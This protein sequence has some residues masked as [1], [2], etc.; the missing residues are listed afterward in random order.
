MVFGE[1]YHRVLLLGDDS[2]GKTTFLRRL[3]FGEIGG[4]EPLP[5]R[6]LDIETI[7]YPATYQWTIWEF[8]STLLTLF[9]FTTYILVW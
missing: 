2:C 8:R 5:T 3:K 4:Q 7:N 6:D 1:K 9:R